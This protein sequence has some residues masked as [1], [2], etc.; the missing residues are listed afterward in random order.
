[1]YCAAAPA[2]RADF[3]WFNSTTNLVYYADALTPLFGNKADSGVSCLVQLVYAGLNDAIDP[4]DNVNSLM[5]TSDDDL[6]VAWSHI[7]ANLPG[8][9]GST[10]HYGRVS[11]GLLSSVVTN[12]QYF[13]R[14]WTAPSAAYAS[15]YAPTAPGVTYGNSDLFTA[16]AGYDPPAPP[17]DFNFGGAGIVASFSPIPEPNSLLLALVGLCTLR[18]W[19][20]RPS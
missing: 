13:V 10:S 6:V 18:R 17:Q 7:G 16:L 1:L 11:G 4:A 12:G 8:V 19:F 5:G 9:A 20:R 3:T 2:A 15:G 14:A